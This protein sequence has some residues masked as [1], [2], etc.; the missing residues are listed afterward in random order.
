[1]RLY[2]NTFLSTNW[3]G[4]SA[5][6]LTANYFFQVLF[7]ARDVAVAEE[8]AALTRY[9]GVVGFLVASERE[10]LLFVVILA[11]AFA[12]F[13]LVAT[14]V[15]AEAAVR[16][17]VRRVLLL[18]M[19][20]ELL[21]RWHHEILVVLTITGM[22]STSIAEDCSGTDYAVGVNLLIKYN[23]IILRHH[24]IYAAV[25]DFFKFLD[26][27]IL[28]LNYLIFFKRWNFSARWEKYGTTWLL[29]C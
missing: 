14:S 22:D 26:F 1:M 5:L 17:L 4:S 27:Y 28:L 15:G 21:F 20:R 10:E 6:L 16:I 19:R 24:W 9:V 8:A 11:H 29:C 23:Y 18:F 3:I 13:E 25:P 12:W 7:F 2:N